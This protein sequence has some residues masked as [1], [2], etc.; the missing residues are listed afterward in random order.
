MES[1]DVAQLLLHQRQQFEVGIAARVQF[2]AP[3]APFLHADGPRVRR[4]LL[5][6]HEMAD[7]EP[8]ESKGR[9][10][11]FEETADVRRGQRKKIAPAHDLRE[12]DETGDDPD[13]GHAETQQNSAVE[14]ARF[15]VFLVHPRSIAERPSAPATQNPAGP[16]YV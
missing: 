10:S 9:K 6:L 5:L 16:G 15:V 12:V 1:G 8:Q 13:A 3:R 14:P 7:D 4:D 2:E 11:T